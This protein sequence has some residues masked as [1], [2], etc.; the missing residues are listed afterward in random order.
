ME[1]TA[2]TVAEGK[3]SKLARLKKWR[4]SPVVS[5][6][7]PWKRWEKHS[8]DVFWIAFSHAEADFSILV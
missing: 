4:T 2:R 6:M 8:R 1:D 3:I 7:V 5:D